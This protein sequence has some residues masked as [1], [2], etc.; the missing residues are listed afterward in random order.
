[1]PSTTDS[2]RVCEFCGKPL[3]FKE[4]PKLFGMESK[5]KD[6]NDKPF[7]FYRDCKCAEAVK[8][9]Q[10]R[11]K[12]EEARRKEE[13][14][15]DFYKRLERAGVKKRY[16]KATHELE[17]E[18]TQKVLEGK[19]LYICGEFGTGKTHLASAIARKLV[20]KRKRVRLLTGIDITMMLQATYGSSESE[21]DVLKRLAKVP[22]LIIDDLGK[23]PPSD[24]VLSR[25][26]AVINA[27]YDEMLPTVITTNYEKSA[28]VERM[29]KH[30]D[31]DT[32]EAMVSRICEMCEL[33]KMDGKDRRLA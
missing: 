13:E 33:I 29:G 12:A 20:W 21:A 24:W 16:E 2:P 32:A 18:N 31:H 19:S 25:L 8:Y 27:R 22:V 28:L 9:R 17:P 23:E 26:F 3:E 11:E 14:R 1:M 4:M 10:E 7:G 30:G 6:G 5:D 15:R